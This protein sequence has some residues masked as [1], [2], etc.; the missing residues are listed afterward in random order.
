MRREDEL[1]T[2]IARHGR[3]VLDLAGDLDEAGFV[4]RFGDGINPFGA[5]LSFALVAIG[6]ACRQLVGGG[7]PAGGPAPAPIVTAH[8][9][10]DWRGWIGLRN[11]L[12]HGYHRR[13]PPVIWR[14]IGELRTLVQVCEARTT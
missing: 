10:I 5:A 14:A 11:V 4:Q 2:D 9:G 12:T 6:E 1:V 3:L 13:D 7:S 8:P